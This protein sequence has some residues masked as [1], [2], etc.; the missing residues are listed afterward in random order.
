MNLILTAITF[1][2][3]SWHNVCGPD[4]NQNNNPA[5]GIDFN[6]N[7]SSYT[8]LTL[9]NSNSK[10]TILFSKNKLY[11]FYGAMTGYNE[12]IVPFIAPKIDIGPARLSCLSDFSKTVFCVMTLK[13]S[14][15]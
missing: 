5:I 10:Q 9:P 3:F 2:A 8:L 15:K 14:L 4:C 1:I 6:Y 11:Y 13:W 7:K 12:F